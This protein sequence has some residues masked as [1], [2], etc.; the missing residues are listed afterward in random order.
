MNYEKYREKLEEGEPVLSY[1]RKLYS[2]SG[3]KVYAGKGLR[4]NN[5]KT[6]ILLKQYSQNAF[7]TTINIF[8]PFTQFINFVFLSLVRFKHF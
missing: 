1:K 8:S 4:Y 3:G 2:F 6:S 7:P 5:G